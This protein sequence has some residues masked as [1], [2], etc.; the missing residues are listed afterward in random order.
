M[1]SNFFYIDDSTFII[2][3]SFKNVLLITFYP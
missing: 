3:S 1:I 2:F